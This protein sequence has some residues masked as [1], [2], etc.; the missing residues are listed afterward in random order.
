MRG[1]ISA[2]LFLA[3]T[4]STSALAASNEFG[5][6]RAAR[7]QKICEDFLS[8]A[9]YEESHV[10]LGENHA[11]IMA[12]KPEKNSIEDRDPGVVADLIRIHNNLYNR[13]DRV[14]NEGETPEKVRALWNEFI[15]Q[16]A[17]VQFDH[18]DPRLQRL[19][20]DSIA[21]MRLSTVMEPG[22]DLGGMVS[23]A[24]SKLWELTVAC[25]FTG[26][27][28]VIGKRVRDI[29]P[30]QYRKAVAANGGEKL[31]GDAAVL[32]NRELDVV[33]K[34]SDGSWRWI[35]VKDWQPETTLSEKK[36][37]DVQYQSRGQNRARL[38]VGLDIEMLLV[39]KYGTPGLDYLEYRVQSQYDDMLFVFPEGM[40][41]Y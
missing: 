37:K 25:F 21:S 23:Q 1:S 16:L 26:E 7:V 28:I 5:I 3:L 27:D 22:K 6:R 33:I 34:M 11:P 13:R 12:L 30:E 24:T 9:R 32:W 14:R 17:T 20:R 31:T 19:L 10:L 4:I 36:K 35:E 8:D 41:Q 38:A 39:M 29:Y 40:P 18:N 2:F 15:G